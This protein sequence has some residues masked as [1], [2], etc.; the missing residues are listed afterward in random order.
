VTGADQGE[1]R[2]WL[3]RDVLV[4]GRRVDCRLRGALVLELGERL[5]AEPGEQELDGGGGALL[6]G[7]ADHHLHLLATAARAESVDLHGA[8]DLAVLAGLPGEGWLRVVGAGAELVRA[9]VDAVVAGRPV[10]VQHRS[11]ALWTLN[12]AAVAQLADGLTPHERA[13]GQLWRSDQRLRALLGPARVPDVARLGA[14]LAARGVTHVTDATPDLDADTCALLAAAVPQ[15]LLAL[16][17]PDGPGPVKVV[18]ADSALPALADL[19]TAFGRAR[20][21]DRPVAVHCVT[22]EALALTLAALHEVGPRPGD[23]VEHAAVC[24]DGAARALAAAGVCVVTQPGIAVGR[25]DR[26]L[27]EVPADDRPLLWRVGSLRRL[28]VPVAL[29]SDAPHADPDLSSDAPHADPDPWATIAAAADRRTAAGTVIGPAEVVPAADALAMLTTSLLD[30]AGSPRAVA[31]GEAADL[32]LLAGPLEE[33]LATAVSRP[34]D[35][36]VR[37]TFVDG[38]LVHRS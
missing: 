20:D 30:P 29:S 8:T 2:G 25:G 28:G 17:A 36:G 12:A 9:D 18:V 37:A 3:L 31:P 15:H 1:P 27:A 21:L 13:T 22:L 33:A 11:G 7:L 24:D 35:V 32:C 10:R 16:G 23:R 34:A 5:P 19:V 38:R 4:G 26:M 14:W 6:P